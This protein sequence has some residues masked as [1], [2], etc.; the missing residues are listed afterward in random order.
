MR[1]EIVKKEI[2]PGEY[3]KFRDVFFPFSVGFDT[4]FD[5]L[6]STAEHCHATSN[7]PP[8]NILK[9]DSK[10][11]IEVALAGYKR[12]NIDVTV[13]DGVLSIVGSKEVLSENTEVHQTYR[14]I[15]NRNFIRKFS[16][17]EYVEVNSAEFKD[18]L[19]TVELEEVLP[20]E[21]KPKQIIIK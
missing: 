17:G 2:T 7:F 18:G 11:Y 15:A 13:E 9:S 10:T 5:R 8:Y 21:K 12:N 3:Q 1:T 20:P 16:L 4:F 19:L 6:N 14:G